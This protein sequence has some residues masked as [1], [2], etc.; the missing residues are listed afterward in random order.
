MDL[1]TIPTSLYRLEGTNIKTPKIGFVSTYCQLVN[2]IWAQASIQ[3]EIERIEPYVISDF[4]DWRERWTDYLRR[5]LPAFSKSKFSQVSGYISAWE[6]GDNGWHP[7]GS[8]NFIVKDS[9]TFSFSFGEPPTFSLES[10][11]ARVMAHEIGH[12]LNLDHVDSPGI[13]GPA[14]LMTSGSRGTYLIPD[15][16]RRSREA[17]AKLV[18]TS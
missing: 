14:R 7:I 10:D 4:Q 15:E 13:V 5:E 12:V 11:I 8:V 6:N 2:K 16:I 1:I 18:G 17:A 9:P 3:F